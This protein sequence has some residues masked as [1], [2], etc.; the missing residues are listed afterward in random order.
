MMRVSKKNA[1]NGM[2]LQFM[3][4]IMSKERVTRAPKS[5]KMLI[6]RFLFM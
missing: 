5:S 1:R 3:R 2:R 4:V 6:A